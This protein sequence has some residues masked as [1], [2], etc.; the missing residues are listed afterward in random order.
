MKYYHRF[1]T[2]T[3]IKLS[4]FLFCLGQLNELRKATFS[5]V[6][7]NNMEGMKTI[8]MKSMELE[9]ESNQRIPCTQV[10]HINLESWQENYEKQGNHD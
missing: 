7:C 4:L 2:T 3:A 1:T 10:P 5:S 6:L 9:A 8:S